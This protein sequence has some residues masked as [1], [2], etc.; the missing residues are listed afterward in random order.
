M[1]K[2]GWLLAGGLATVAAVGLAAT[3]ARAEPAART[4]QQPA[5]RPP[6]RTAPAARPT[7]YSARRLAA[8]GVLRSADGHY[9]L[10]VTARGQARL[11]TGRH[12]VWRTPAAG[13]RAV[14]TVSRDGDL[15]L[16]ARGRTVWQA[17]TRGDAGSRL[18]VG[19]GAVVLVDRYGEVWSSRQGN[20]CRATRAGHEI[21]VDLSRQRAWLCSHG[22]QVLTTAVTTGATA[23]GNGTPTGTWHVVAK[24]RNTT[25]HPSSGGAYR[26]RY[27][28]PYDGA[29]GL[30]DASWQRIGYG[31]A[32][33]RTQGS[34]GCVHVPVAQLV[35]LFRWAPVGTTVRIQR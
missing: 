6:T 21:L 28:L 30:H 16:V 34:H 15:V 7:P 26:V 5:S 2:R 9:L 23:R 1:A 4:T 13:P 33:Y 8:G 14:L 20:V 19:D 31:T 11:T 29:Y 35:Y 32:Q 24:V 27:W 25:L 12:V 10:S 3:L 22:R 17:N 18:T